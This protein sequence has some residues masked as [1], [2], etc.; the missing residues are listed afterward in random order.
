MK[1]RDLPTC[2]GAWVPAV[3]QVQRNSYWLV[4]PMVEVPF[5][6]GFPAA[7]HKIPPTPKL[8]GV[9]TRSYYA[10]Y[11]IEFVQA[12]LRSDWFSGATSI[13]D[14][15][16]GAGTT[17]LASLAEGLPSHGVDINPVPL[18]LT[19]RRLASASELARARRFAL[20]RFEAGGDVSEPLLHRWFS[21]RASADFLGVSEAI[22][23][24]FG[25][26]L[27]PLRMGAAVSSEQVVAAILFIALGAAAR[28][29]AHAQTTNPTWLKMRIPSRN[30]AR[31]HAVTIA[32]TLRQILAA[33]L[34]PC[35]SKQKDR[36]L[37]TLHLRGATDL[38]LASGTVGAIITSPPYLT[39]IDYAVATSAELAVLSY[40]EE[41]FELLRRSQT[42]PVLAQ[43]LNVE[44]T[45]TGDSAI[46]EV[47]RKIRRHSS[48]AAESYYYPTIRSYFSGLNEALREAHRTLTSQAHF[49]LVLQNSYFKDILIDLPQLAK[50][51]A[52][53]IGF[54]HVDQI[55]Y[56]CSSTRATMHPHRA[57]WRETQAKTE[58]FIILRKTT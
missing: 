54:K 24:E 13:L 21:K 44:D 58:S 51:Q 47:L 20:R 29:L 33:Q 9:G 38:G 35:T 45:E 3:A 25:D 49:G 46:A 40:S 48:K 15:W 10:G 16:C 43:P 17:C 41:S 5:L 52:E 36:G 27:Q 12:V 53:G 57:S 55:D 14:P 31:A 2:N 19:L 37:V 32:N 28:Q 1:S 26:P 34:V 7:V 11:S 56:P 30:R 39:R 18:L 8:G 4:A 23:S 50:E 42:G 6:M 22:R